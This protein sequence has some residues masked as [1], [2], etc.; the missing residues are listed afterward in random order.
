MYEYKVVELREGLIGGK[1]SGDKLERILN[2]HA[3][4]G[5]QL[6][7]IT[8]VEVKGRIG[9]GGVDGILVTFERQR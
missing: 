3:S 8:S 9:P 5:W 4:K 6:K 7:A 1:M 2:D